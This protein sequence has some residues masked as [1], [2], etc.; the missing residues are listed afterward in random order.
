MKK[1][2]EELESEIK[3]SYAIPA[4]QKKKYHLH[5][6]CV[7]DG[8]ANSGHYYSFI[9]DRFNKKWRKF[10]DIRVTD[11]E[12]EAVFK[13]SEGGQGWQT[14]Q[15][16]VY[17]EDS[18]AGVLDA[19]NI[20]HYSVPKNPFELQDFA[21]HLYGNIV[22]SEVNSL[23]EKENSALAKEII[24]QKNDKTVSDIRTIYIKRF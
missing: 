18:I 4:M 24:D 11:V 12:E 10:N 6:I 19:N 3:A 16:L 17:V 15:W 22:P 23:I 2:S 13:E 14:A 1:K 9:M 7:H 20:T 8:N 5:S 21:K